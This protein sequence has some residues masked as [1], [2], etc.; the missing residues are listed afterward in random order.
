MHWAVIYLFVC[1]FIVSF[2]LEQPPTHTKT[3]NFFLF[4]VAFVFHDPK[5]QLP[6][7]LSY[8]LDVSDYSLMI[9][10]R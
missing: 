7:R 3:P 2:N 9:R 1:L 5:G 4:V 6:H 8:I 10:R